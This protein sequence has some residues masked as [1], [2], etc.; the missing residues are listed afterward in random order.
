MDPDEI[1]HSELPCLG[2]HCLPSSLL[3]GNVVSFE[4]FGS[5]FQGEGFVQIIDFFMCSIH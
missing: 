4:Q 1:A 3:T 5:G 2:L